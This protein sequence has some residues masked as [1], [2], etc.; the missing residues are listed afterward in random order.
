MGSDR[1]APARAP[2]SRTSGPLARPGNPERDLPC[3]ARRRFLAPRAFRLAAQEPLCGFRTSRK[4]K[5]ASA[6]GIRSKS[7]IDYRGSI[8]QLL[9]RAGEAEC[10][11]LLTVRRAGSERYSSL[12]GSL[13]GVIAPLWRPSSGRSLCPLFYVGHQAQLLSSWAF[14]CPAVVRTLGLDPHE[15]PSRHH[16]A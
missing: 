10:N 7:T 15:Q 4:P 5:R 16:P 14:S 13:T 6:I 3:P 1:A 11:G 8:R 2:R 9:S 12:S